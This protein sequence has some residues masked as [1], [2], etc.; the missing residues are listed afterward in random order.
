MSASESYSSDSGY[1]PSSSTTNGSGSYS[2]SDD[3]AGHVHFAI[4]LSTSMQREH[5]G[6]SYKKAKKNKKVRAKRKKIL[7]FLEKLTGSKPNKKHKITRQEVMLWHV[8]SAASKLIHSDVDG[9]IDLHAFSDGYDHN[10]MHIEVSKTKDIKKKILPY[11]ASLHGAKEKGTR[12]TPVFKHIIDGYLALRKKTG[13]RA[14]VFLYTDGTFKDHDDLIKYYQKATRKIVKKGKFDH[15]HF[16]C[17]VVISHEK[18]VDR[19]KLQQL[20]SDGG[21][22][23]SEGH[24]LIDVKDCL[25]VGTEPYRLI[26]MARNG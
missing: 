13:E 2:D 20:D 15:D 23:V 12:V 8:Y 24:D 5:K 1:S 16:G 19:K 21:E 10:K 11:L 22:I 18:G 25:R 3:E 26:S 9:T 6:V 7:K 4:D 17:L 14:T